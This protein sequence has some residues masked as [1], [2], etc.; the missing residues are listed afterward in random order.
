MAVRTA[1]SPFTPVLIEAEAG[2]GAKAVAALIHTQTVV[3]SSRALVSVRCGGTPESAID[4]ELFGGRLHAGS[5]GDADKESSSESEGAIARARGGSLFIEEIELVGLGA[6][7]VLM[8]LIDRRHQQAEQAFRLI[9]SSTGDLQERVRQRLFRLDLLEQFGIIHL[10]IPPLRDR[11]DEIIAL[12]EQFIL[13]HVRQLGQTP[14]RLSAEARNKLL[15]HGFPRNVDELREVIERALILDPAEVLSADSIQFDPPM[16]EAV[17]E[18]AASSF[19]SSHI[20]RTLAERKRPPTLNEI[21]RDY[22]IWLLRETGGN[23]TVVARQM[24][25]SYPTVMK[26]ISDY[27]IDLQQFCRGRRG[28]D[29]ATVHK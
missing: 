19:V 12:A 27:K 17:R 28:H 20:L 9:A 6:Q 1:Q 4:A 15:Q 13:S 11:R 25:V 24:G 2:A 3:T 14:S 10:R 29:P 5:L 7:T 16:V 21:E 18:D 26:K 23:R 8:R 22:L